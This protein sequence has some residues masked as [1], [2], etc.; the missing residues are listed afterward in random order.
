MSLE[1]PARSFAAITPHAATNFAG[2]NARSIYVGGTGDVAVV[3]ADDVAV[4]FVG[5]VGGSILPVI[6]KRVNAIGTTATNLIA[7]F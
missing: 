2:G 6:C 1:A 4:V 7:L 3:G 5:V